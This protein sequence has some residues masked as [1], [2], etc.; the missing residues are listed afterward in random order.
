MKIEVWKGQTKAP[1]G[2]VL[3]P[4]VL[5]DTKGDR[6][7]LLIH[8]EGRAAG[9]DNLREECTSVLTHAVLEGEGDGYDRLESALKELN[10]L[11]KGF[12]L[13]EAVNDVH[14]VVGLLEQNG[15]LH[16]SHV[17]RAEAYVIRDGTAVQ[18]TEYARSKPPMAFMHIVSGPVQNRDHFIIATTRLLRSMTPAQLAQT[19]QHG[20]ET[21]VQTIVQ[22]LTAEKESACILHIALVGATEEEEDAP[23]EINRPTTVRRGRHREKMSGG[24]LLSSVSGVVG[25]VDWSKLFTRVRGSHGKKKSLSSITE[26]V[27]QF[28]KDL[29]DP[30]RKRR[31]HLLLLAGSAAAFL[32]IWMLVQLTLSSQKSQT[33]GQ[34]AEL[35]K[36]INADI[37]TAE[38]RQLAG[39]TD[40]ANA[41]LE[42]AD[43]R[44]RQV[45]TNESGLYRSEA[46]E[47]LDRIKSKREEMNR[48]I[49]VTPPRVMANLSGKKADILAQGFIGLS[50]GEFLVYDRQDLY[51]VSLNTVESADRL[52]SEE[53]IL[54]GDNFPRFQS[55]VFMTTGN[56]VIEILSSQP[57]TMKT[58]DTAG[59]IT[60]A[61]IKTYLRYLYILAPERKQIYKYE[62][63]ASRYGPPAEYNVN[64]DLTGA[65][66]MTITGAVYVLKDIS[67]SGGEAGERDV[68]KL[69]R[70]EK[71]TFNIRNLP[72]GALNGVT[73]IFK[74]G[75]N[76]NFYFLDPEAKR[77][78]VTTHDGDLG[79]SLYLKQYVLDSEQVGRLKDLFVD[80]EDSRLYVLDEK[81]LYAIDLQAR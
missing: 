31:A 34:L 35:V 58:E 54:D 59:W 1:A 43:D 66:D 29:Y 19:V 62:R 81:K 79:D 36:Q 67:A 60:G 13:S 52:G 57:T 44:A 26:A 77:V 2:T 72:P 47:L 74:S 73:K 40:S 65:L 9:S 24:A 28:L 7:F 38:T 30:E 63:L 71:Q 70:G 76:G 5:G 75:V 55:K 42:R 46:L 3:V 12:L 64:G 16:L 8:S 69:L 27:S 25:R 56:S 50:N 21:A 4:V 6:V 20:G 10:G 22:T 37:S 14:A 18:I 17:G 48:V 49:R 23:R 41:I 32:I 39:E 51:S 11:L 61:D 68:V 33:K 80:A 53:L 15:T 45:M 78:V